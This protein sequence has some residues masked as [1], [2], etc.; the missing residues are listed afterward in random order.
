M[1]LL[2]ITV[3]LLASCQSNWQQYDAS[4]F[5]TVANP[6]QEAYEYHIGTLERMVEEDPPPP[7]LCAELGYF[8]ILVG[9]TAEADAWFARELAAYPHAES[10]VKML[11]TT[12]GLDLKEAQ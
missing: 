1:R 5:E 2:T 4:L 10:Y 12:M 11:R 7:G 6:S 3:A 8:L 9:R